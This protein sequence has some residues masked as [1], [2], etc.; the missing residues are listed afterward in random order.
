MIMATNIKSVVEAGSRDRATNELMECGYTIVRRAARPGSLASIA[1][2]LAPLFAAA[3]F[4]DG[5]F[6]G[7]R[8]KRFGTLLS[9]CPATADLVLNPQILALAHHALGPWCDTI[10]LNLTQAIEIHGGALAQFPHRDQDMWRGDVGT[11]EYLINVMWPLVPF[12]AENGATVIWPASHGPA[13]LSDN[14]QRSMPIDA[15]ANPGDAIVFLGST[16]HGGGANN[17][18]LPRQAII[19][20]YCLG[21]LKPYENQWLAYPPAVARDF[22]PALADI[23]GYQQHRPNLG[24]VEG[25]CPSRLFQDDQADYVCAIDALLPEQN[26]ML[27]EYV[28]TQRRQIGA[29]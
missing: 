1:G 4:C 23:V 21:W 15:I 6:Y 27:A 16:L 29:R 20:S 8:T 3:P 17:T 9:R 18:S 13:A 2:D 28:A 26:V 12:T 25:Q 22:T 10:Q 7:A 5:D 14:A 24:N 19:V 11:R